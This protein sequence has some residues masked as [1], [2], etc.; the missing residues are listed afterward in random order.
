[1][2]YEERYASNAHINVNDSVTKSKFDN[3]YGCRGII[4][5]Y[6][7]RA[8]GVMAGKKPAVVAGWCSRGKGLKLVERRWSSRGV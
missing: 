2:T 7:R 3:K 1:M 8:T 6:G 5:R 4:G